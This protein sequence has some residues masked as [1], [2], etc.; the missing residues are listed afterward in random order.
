MHSLSDE[1]WNKAQARVRNRSTRESQSGTII[2]EVRAK[3]LEATQTRQNITQQNPSTSP[4]QSPQ[5][6]LIAGGSC[7]QG[8]DPAQRGGAVGFLARRREL[9]FRY[10]CHDQNCLNTNN[11]CF[12]DPGLN[13]F[14]MENIH[15]DL[16]A[17]SIDVGHN[18][19]S[20]DRPPA[21]LFNYWMFKQGH[22]TVHSRRSILERALPDMEGVE[23]KLERL[24]D[25]TLQVSQLQALQAA[26]A[27]L[28]SCRHC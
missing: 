1:E 12:I 6:D 28:N 11:F 10:W 4:I 22:V 17:R 15:I 3:T 2:L 26:S 19:C 7:I 20:M 25:L 8:S 27:T 16:W 13:H 24:L 21:E 14:I 18:D 9:E 5:D 23:R